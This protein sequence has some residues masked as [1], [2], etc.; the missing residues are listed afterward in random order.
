MPEH[1]FQNR[2]VL[3]AAI[4]WL[5]CGDNLLAQSAFENQVLLV[6]LT[7]AA[8]EQLN[9]TSSEG[10]AATGLAS[11]DALNREHRAISMQRVFRPAGKHE[12]AHLAKGLQRYYKL[13]FAAEADAQ[14]LAQAYAGD[15]NVEFAQPNWR[16][17]LLRAPDALCLPNDPIFPSQWNLHNTGQTGGTSDADIDA[18]EAWCLETGN[19]DAVVSILDT[20]IDLDHPELAANMWSNPGEIAGNGLD[21]DGNGFIDDVHGWDF[22]DNDNNPDDYDSHGAH[23]AGIIAARANNG[24]GI[25]GIAGGWGNVAGVSLMACKIFPNAFDDVIAEAFVYAADNGSRISNNA[26]GGAAC[27]S[28]VIEDAI[29]YFLAASDGVV[30]FGAGASN[31]SNPC[32]GYPASYPPA[33]AVA[34]LDQN[35]HKTSFSNYGDWID[36]S[37]PGVNIWSTI[38]G[39]YASY[40]GTS[41]A[42]S[43]A[44]GV[45][46]L[47]LS[48]HPDWTGPQLREQLESSA[49]NIDAANPGFVGLLG[50]GRVNAF[51]AL[52]GAV[53]P[54][55]CVTYEFSIATGAWYLIS[56]P[57]IPD[58]NA[59]N[60]LFPGASAAFEWSHATQSYAQV[61]T[62]EPEKAYWLLMPQAATVHVCGQPLNSYTRIYGSPG[63]DLTGSV[64]E[65]SPLVDDPD[66]SILAMFSWNSETQTYLPVDPFV[67]EPKQGYWILVLETPS[68]VTVGNGLARGEGQVAKV[69]AGAEL[70]AFYAKYGALPP[71]PPFSVAG[72]QLAVIRPAD[73]G[74][75][76]NYPNPFNPETV[77]EY[78]L[79]QPA[80]VS[81]K[82][83]NLLGREIRSLVDREM[84]AGYHRV[85]WDGRDDAGRKMD[86]GVYLYKIHVGNFMQTRKTLLLK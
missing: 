44:T 10:V 68:T 51:N 5:A 1:L 21:D 70:Q 8:A 64:F 25:S 28:P 47:L 56:L 36:V 2:C 16:Y 19:P 74:L 3:F 31:S 72:D 37:A 30:M 6:K 45:A 17:H 14:A 35:D 55:V 59:V 79:P 29:D 39:G 23:G 12:A 48:A 53:T 61:S 82:I 15:E 22:S 33:V 7:A 85:K 77:I 18:P 84:P 52:S 34:A 76:Q 78:Q 83:Y 75:S 40:S 4:V 60:V 32:L 49:D 50:S 24:V 58:S 11:F 66:G 62:L 71:P 67:V 54:P 80:K 81:L 43:H 65:T 69:S 26:W 13:R 73:Y 20:G 63:W 27:P 57:V 9:L 41:P 46:A 42:C 38:I 86:S